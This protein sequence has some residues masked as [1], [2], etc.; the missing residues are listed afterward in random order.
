MRR[1]L[2]VA[3][4]I[5]LVAALPALLVSAARAETAVVTIDFE[6]LAEGSTADQV[7]VGSG[8]TGAAVGGAIAIRGERRSLPGVNRAMIFDG[9]CLPLGSWLGCTGLD[10]DLFF[11]SL[12]NLLIV[13]ENGSAA[14]PNDA[15][16][17]ILTFDFRGFGPGAVRVESFVLADTDSRRPNMTLITAAGASSTTRLPATGNRASTVVSVGASDIVEM[18]IDLRGEGAVDQIVLAVDLA[19]PPTSTTT[20]TTTA[21]PDTTPPPTPTTTTTTTT[22]APPSGTPGPLTMTVTANG[23]PAGA[24]PGPSL[25][26]GVPV[27]WTYDV[28]NGGT[29]NLWALYIWHEGVGRADCADR[30]LSPGETVRCTA[31]STAVTGAYSAS[32]TAQ[33]WDDAGAEAAVAGEAHY[34]VDSPIFVPAPAIDLE[35]LVGGDDA[36]AAP[37]PVLLPGSSVEFRYVA[38]NTG[39]VELWGLWVRDGAFGTITCPTRYLRPGDAVTCVTTRTVAAGVFTATAEAR[40]WDAA[41]AEVVD[42]DPHHYLGATGTPSIDIEALV[43]GFDGDRPPG[44]RVRRPGEEILFTYVVTNTGGLGLT[45]VRVSDNALGAVACPGTALAPGQSM[46]CNAST[47][48]RLGEFAST[49]RVTADS[50]A[51]SVSDSDPIYYHVRTEPRIHNLALE[52]AVNGRDADDAASAPS[53]PVGGSARFTYV[54]TYTGNNI[55]YNVTIQDPRIAESRI[56]CSGDRTLTAG[57]TLRCTA[58][59][60]AVAGPYA[61]LVTV[62]SWDADGRRVAAED[63]VHYYGMA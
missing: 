63:W 37:G 30:A 62:V 7:A 44:P 42:T 55:V 48:A 50:A 58:T 59:V 8:A 46:T 52:V 51:G 54:I 60:P 31:A 43:E 41:G 23:A 38:R 13:S 9:A 45:G 56:S 3:V 40:A 35:T 6:G 57:E 61:S 12:G 1:G 34:V 5:A 2:A 25:T 15:R 26:A 19:P 33:A 47:I 14:N 39:N 17:G 11:P 4:V 18:T 16:D 29:G 28:T 53:I 32:V 49:G 10:P 27:A 22:A 20:T 36:D 21:P 24:A